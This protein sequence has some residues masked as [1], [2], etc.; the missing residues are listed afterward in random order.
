MSFWYAVRRPE[1]LMPLHVVTELNRPFCKVLPT[2]VTTI[3]AC[4]VSISLSSNPGRLN[5]S[6]LTLSRIFSMLPLNFLT[7]HPILLPLLYV[8]FNHN[9][10][11]SQACSLRR[12]TNGAPGCT[13][14]SRLPTPQTHVAKPSSTNGSSWRDLLFSTP[15]DV[16]VSLNTRSCSRRSIGT[17]GLSRVCVIRRGIRCTRPK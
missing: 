7:P 4:M 10:P 17:S 13:R 2:I 11:S 14:H 9:S 8:H 16:R 5:P 15:F 1:K 3:K 6:S 12:S